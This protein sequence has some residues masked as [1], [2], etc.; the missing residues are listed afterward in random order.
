MCTDGSG[1]ACLMLVR[2]QG[3]TERGENVSR[4]QQPTKYVGKALPDQ[5]SGGACLPYWLVRLA[6]VFMF[7]LLFLILFWLVLCCRRMR[8]SVMLSPTVAFARRSR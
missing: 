4:E 7:L 5:P 1:T 3:T 2:S 8:S 6:L